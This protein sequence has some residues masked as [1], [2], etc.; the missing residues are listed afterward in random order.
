VTPYQ[1]TALACRLAAA[2]SAGSTIWTVTR[3]ERILTTALAW[4]AV[5]LMFLGGRCQ[6]VHLADR[7]RHEQARRAA[8]ADSIAL[9][10]P[11]CSFWRHSDG[12]VHGPDCT[13]PPAVRHDDYRLDPAMAATFEEITGH[14][15]EGLTS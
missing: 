11:C 1:R 3:H 7:A 15:D 2:A 6:K 5:F 4:G 13:R 12:A 9:A 14:F 10:A 8:H